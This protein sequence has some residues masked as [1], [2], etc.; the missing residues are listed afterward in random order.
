MEL[1]VTGISGASALVALGYYG[2]SC[3]GHVKA[4]HLI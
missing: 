3:W 1:A 4:P 2:M